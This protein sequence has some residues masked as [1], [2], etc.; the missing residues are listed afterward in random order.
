MASFTD[1]PPPSLI[2]VHD[3]V[4]DDGRPCI[5]MEY[6]P[7]HTLGDLLKGGGTLLRPSWLSRS[8]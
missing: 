1:P 7:G 6:V 5:V 4:E 8:P 3:V 2:V